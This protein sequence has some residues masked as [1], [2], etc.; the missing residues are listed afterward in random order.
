[1]FKGLTTVSPAIIPFFECVF[2]ETTLIS[3]D[4][5]REKSRQLTHCSSICDK[6]Q[7]TFPETS[8]YFNSLWYLYWQENNRKV[9]VKRQR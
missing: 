4:L 6:M 5:S 9:S 2:N 8:S 7:S 1:M 3:S